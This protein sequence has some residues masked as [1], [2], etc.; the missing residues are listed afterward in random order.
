MGGKYEVD[1]T[2][3]EK[4]DEFGFHL[5]FV[6]IGFSLDVEELPLDFPGFL[7]RGAIINSLLNLKCIFGKPCDIC[8]KAMWK[9]FESIGEMS[10]PGAMW[11]LEVD[12]KY[13]TDDRKEN[14]FNTEEKQA[15]DKLNF[16]IGFLGRYV[17]AYPYFIHAILRW[18]KRGILS[19]MRKGKR[20][21][22][23]KI[24][25]ID[26][27]KGNR[28]DP[29]YDFP[30][31]GNLFDIS[32]F[33][34]DRNERKQISSSLIEIKFISPFISKQEGKFAGEED[35]N[36]SLL[37]SAVMRRIIS[38]VKTWEES[39]IISHEGSPPTHQTERLIEIYKKLKGETE[40]V[41][42]ERKELRKVVLQ[43]PSERQKK[44]IKMEGI[45]G[46]MTFS[47]KESSA[48]ELLKWLLIGQEIGAGK[49]VRL[50]LGRY[51]ISI[52]PSQ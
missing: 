48:Y 40:G 18:K 42:M 15:R 23:S 47:F 45:V 49:G 24:E 39:G 20:I 8:S 34:V 9:P 28:F 33:G 12:R 1:S 3:K 6:K 29:K 38:E 27:L 2:D 4:K 46:S 26:L 32:R 13:L 25:I 11:Y 19:K 50:G 44:L 37:F 30:D 31:V 43:K 21:K 52:L 14:E 17:F 10:T 16:S 51:V 22:I 5:P 41:K 36:F 7:I 35:F